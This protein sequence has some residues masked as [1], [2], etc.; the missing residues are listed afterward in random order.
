MPSKPTPVRHSNRFRRSPKPSPC[1][2]RG[3]ALPKTRSATQRTV[4]VAAAVS[5]A[6]TTAA[7]ACSRRRKISSSPIIV[8]AAAAAAAAVVVVVAVVGRETCIEPTVVDVVRV[9]PKTRAAPTRCCVVLRPK[10]RQPIRPATA[11]VVAAA[12]PTPHTIPTPTVSTHPVQPWTV[13]RLPLVPRHTAVV[14][15][16]VALP[17]PRAPTQS[18]VVAATVVTTIDMSPDTHQTVR[19]QPDATYATTAKT[20]QMRTGNV[21]VRR[22]DTVHGTTADPHDPHQM[23]RRRLAQR[24]LLHLLLLLRR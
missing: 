4:I 1:T 19:H 18:T 14:R 11:V 6:K 20:G 5:T 17:E 8:V 13:P 24:L 3:I 9:R 22:R 23:P 10:A 12:K 15:G 2:P 16:G 21:V 7:D